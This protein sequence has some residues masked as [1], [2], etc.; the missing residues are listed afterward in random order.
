MTNLLALF[1]SA[2]LVSSTVALT[3]SCGGDDHDLC[4][5][6]GARGN[7]CSDELLLAELL[8]GDDVAAAPPVPDPEPVPP[9]PGAGRT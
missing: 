9:A 1:D 4:R 5:G 7:G 8:L 2:D 6:R 3:T